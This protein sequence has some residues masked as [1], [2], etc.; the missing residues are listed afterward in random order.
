MPRLL[1]ALPMLALLISLAPAP[2]APV[3]THLMPKHPIYY[4]TVVGTKWTKVACHVEPRRVATFVVADV[5][6]EGGSKLVSVAIED[7]GENRIVEKVRIAPDGMFLVQRNQV[8]FDPPVCLLKLPV[9]PGEEWETLNT[10]S[11]VENA[12]EFRYKHTVFEPEW[13]TVPAGR[14]RAVRVV[15]D[16]QYARGGARMWPTTHW[17]VAGIGCVKSTTPGG[18]RDVMTSFT[19]A[20]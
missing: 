20:K 5:K 16:S 10:L 14:F 3:P 4:P 9:K 1:I 12:V 13:V 6:E 17:Y 7:D 8:Q 15:E 11:A 18:R 2:A 19:P